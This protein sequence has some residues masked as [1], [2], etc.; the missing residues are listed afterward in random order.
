MTTT[1]LILVPGF[2]LGAWAWDDVLPGLRAAGLEPHPVTLPGL[3]P[4]DGTDGV[5]RADHVRTVVELV[6]RVTADG[7]DVVLVGHSGGG[8]VVGEV[9]DR[10][11]DRVRRA[12]YVDSGPLENGSALALDLPTDQADLPLPS[13]E[14]LA[15]Q[16]SS[17]DGLDDAAL[18][19]FRERA[20]P[21]PGAVARG[22]VRVGDDRRFAVP[23]TAVCTSLPSGVLRT[24]V[25]GGPPLHTEL[26]R[27]DVTY[28][29]LP[30]GHWPMF[31]RPDDLAAVLVEAARA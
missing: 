23:V 20:V 15:D 18:D 4:A 5:T 12:V 28:V 14:E 19:R 31:S 13:W 2:W 21:H 27:Y 10:R 29:D 7:G 25:D 6:D 8:A 1:H 11:P 9:V 3:D 17:L 24:M 26:G 30:T 22:A 16:G